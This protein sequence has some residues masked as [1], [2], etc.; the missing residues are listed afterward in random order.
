MVEEDL[1]YRGALL[2]I[3]GIV[4]LF[5]LIAVTSTMQLD[6]LDLNRNLGGQAIETG[7]PDNSDEIEFRDQTYQLETVSEGESLSTG[8]DILEVALSSAKIGNATANITIILGDT[9]LREDYAV[10]L[11]RI[12]G[13]QAGFIVVN[14]SIAC[15]IP[16]DG[17]TPLCRGQA[18]CRTGICEQLPSC[19]GAADGLLETWG[20][21][22]LYCCNEELSLE[23]CGGEQ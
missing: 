23:A 12:S 11:M 17:Q 14:R 20:S 5:A 2:A 10:T 1:G 18:A 9:A 21:R 6:F 22:D 8:Y 3:V 7:L 16:V 4:C 13:G 19:T 15:D